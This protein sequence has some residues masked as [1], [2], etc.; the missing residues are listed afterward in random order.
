MRLAWDGKA[1]KELQK[2]DSLIQR[3]IIKC[4]EELEL[5]PSA[6]DVRKLKGIDG[7]RLRVGDYR[8]IFHIDKDIIFISKVG[9]RKGIYKR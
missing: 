9:H 1:L 4:V 8:I 6:K 2:L 7:F 5:N 3:R